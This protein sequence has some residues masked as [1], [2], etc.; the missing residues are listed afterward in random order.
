M[1]PRLQ[2]SWRGD[3]VT[4][5]TAP[6]PDRRAVGVDRRKNSRSGRRRQDPHVSA[7]RWHRIAWLFAGYAAYVSLRSL[8]DTVK[9]WPA[10]LKRLVARK[11]TPLT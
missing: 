8:P 10:I 3:V 6:N 7:W 9:A 2:G 4:G 1:A 5:A 11:R